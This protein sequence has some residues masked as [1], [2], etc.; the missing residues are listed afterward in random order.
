M[1]E[2]NILAPSPVGRVTPA[3][4]IPPLPTGIPILPEQFKAAK[5]K[6]RLPKGLIVVGVIVGL[7]ALIWFRIYYSDYDQNR[8]DP[9]VAQA[10]MAHVPKGTRLPVTL[11]SGPRILVIDLAFPNDQP[12]QAPSTCATLDV[13]DPKTGLK[14][15]DPKYRSGAVSCVDGIAVT[16]R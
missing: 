3:R 11:W 5:V 2:Q 7:A 8:I 10:L 13:L 14:D 16:I 1:S 12:G 6:R 15:T 9:V 4:F